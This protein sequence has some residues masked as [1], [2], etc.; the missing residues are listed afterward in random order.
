MHIIVET[1]NLLK[2][3]TNQYGDWSLYKIV[4][5]D[6]KTYSTLA[7][8]AGVIRHGS[9]IEPESITLDEKHE[10]Q[11]QFKKFTLISLPAG[12][13][14]N[15]PSFNSKGTPGPSSDMSKTDWAEKDRLERWSRECNTCFMGI[16]ELAKE[17]PREGEVCSPKFLAIFD[18]ALDWAMA[19]FTIG[20]PVPDSRKAYS[21]PGPGQTDAKS[22]G[23]SDGLETFYNTCKKAHGLTKEKIATKYPGIDLATTAM[24]TTAWEYINAQES[25]E[26]KNATEDKVT[27]EDLF[28]EDIPF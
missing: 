24:R 28:P 16:V 5:A 17:P 18:A 11:F 25:A 23:V 27:T 8:G 13:S 9:V 20:Q 22:D 2:E 15:E 6:G 19:H 4:S 1:I 14:A 26:K 12:A 10:G 7:E 21:P 3:G